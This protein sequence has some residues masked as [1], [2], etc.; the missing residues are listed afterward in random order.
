MG[1]S[2]GSDPQL[3]KINCRR[4]RRIELENLGFLRNAVKVGEGE[5]L[6]GIDPFG[7]LLREIPRDEGF[8]GA[9][10]H[11]LKAEDGRGRE[12]VDDAVWKGDVR[13][14]EPSGEAVT[15]AGTF[16]VEEVHHSFLSKSVNSSFPKSS[17]VCWMS[18]G[19]SVGQLLET[20]WS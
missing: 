9:V 11:E 12:R 7:Q 10:D 8:P 4:R 2:N 1:V 18:L 13:C 3:V 14:S 19:K 20:K 5:V 6:R 16:G 17:I 15:E